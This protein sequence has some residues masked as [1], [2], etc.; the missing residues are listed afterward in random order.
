MRAGIEFASDRHELSDPLEAIEFCYRQGWTDG[1]PVVPPTEERVR[2]MLEYAG[3]RPD[4]VLGTVPARNITITAEK[5]AINAVMAGCLPAYMPVVAAAVEAMADDRFNLHAAM[6]STAGAA[7]LVIVN[8]PVIREIGLN[9]GD[10]V[11]GPG[12]R[13][14]ATI[15]RALRLVLM[16]VCRARP[17]VMDKATL[18][19]PGKYSYCIAEREAD[20]PWPPLHVQRGVPREVSAVTVFAAE[21]PAY[22]KNDQANRAEP[23]AAS[24][25]DVITRGTPRGGSY[26]LVVCPEHLEVFQREGWSKQDLQTF[27][28]REAKR[29]VASARRAGWLSGAPAEREEDQELLW[30]Q[31][32]ADVM[33]VVA[34]GTTSGTS[35]VVPPWAGGAMSSPVTKG[36]GVCIDCEDEVPFP[37][38]TPF[39]QGGD[40]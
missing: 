30:F 19:H 1:L 37:P 33:V 6:A 9:A 17:G 32:P 23:L 27:V 34:G 2:E 3:Y 29:S 36:I 7:P 21:A 38:L 10:N 13:A 11:F 4:D 31:S 5:V 26:L 39:H 25:V 24:F 18:G 16:N 22:V 14:N 28:A 20:S 12:W 15:G 8:G 40:R 35:A